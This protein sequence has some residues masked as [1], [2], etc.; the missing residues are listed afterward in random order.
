MANNA[1]VLILTDDAKL[2]EEFDSAFR[3]MGDEQPRYRFAV[4]RNQLFEALRTQSVDLILIEFSQKPRELTS[5][6]KQCEGSAP[7]VPVAA[8]LRP[9]GFGDNVSESSI[10]IESMR[11]GVCDFLRRPIS[12][13][14][15][16][17]LLLRSQSTGA[18]ETMREP[19]RVISFISN[20]GG[21]GK[22]TLATN[23]AVGL[24]LKRP[25]SVLL[26]DGSLQMGVGAAL[27]DL[28]PT[29]TLTDLARESD[30]LDAGMLRQVTT[31]HSSGLHLLAAPADAIEAME[32][33]DLLMA[34]VITLARKT[35]DFVVVDTFPMFDRVVIATLD[36]SD[37]A[38]VVLENVL[39]TLL[40]G[41][42]LLEVLDRIGF[43]ATRQSVILNRYQRVTGSLSIDDVATQMGRRIDHVL[44][45]E[46][47]VMM[48]ANVGDPIALRPA[49]FNAF[50]RE[51]QALIG[52]VE[53]TANRPLMT[54][55]SHA[56]ESG[57][58]QAGVQSEPSKSDAEEHISRDAV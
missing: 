31:T 51:L 54:A 22:S 30:R 10:L 6:V 55:D 13:S 38:Y 41:I 32:V 7:G 23:V 18:R 39:P 3:A 21:V 8:I 50:S 37:H 4:D 28:K 46:K 36:L 14:D 58:V 56:V 16:R 42:K 11:A 25:G 1:S 57:K 48:A 24:A 20:K 26:I 44:P 49:R 45:F 19:G 12:T 47:R 33:D 9:E 15:L 2:R 34:R 35:Y 27:L 5:L 53:R 40:G 17:Q 52:D 43:P 29:S